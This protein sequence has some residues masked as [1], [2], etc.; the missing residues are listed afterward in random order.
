MSRLPAIRWVE[1]PVDLDDEY[2]VLPV[3]YSGDAYLVRLRNE[4][5]VWAIYSVSNHGA[6]FLP[7]EDGEEASS[8]DGMSN[9]VA[10]MDGGYGPGVADALIAEGKA[11]HAVYAA[12]V[13]STFDALKAAFA[14]R[15][16]A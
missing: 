2:P 6:C 3:L 8:N 11:K 14:E 5:V 4:S 15:R 13:R 16:S 1:L 9:I 7:S 12:E 10:V